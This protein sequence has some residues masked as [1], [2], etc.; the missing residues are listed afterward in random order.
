MHLVRGTRSGAVISLMCARKGGYEDFT[1][2]IL[3]RFESYWFLNPV[4][5]QYDKS[6]IHVCRREKGENCAAIRGTYESPGQLS[7]W[8]CTRD[9]CMDLHDAAKHK[10]NEHWLAAFSDISSKSIRSSLRWI[11]AHSVTTKRGQPSSRTGGTV[12]AGGN[13][14]LSQTN[15]WWV[16]NA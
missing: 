13:E 14:T 10:R 12:A 9:T 1:R 8:S 7:C 16:R 15:T 5:L 3:R 11:C 2:E 4:I 6:V